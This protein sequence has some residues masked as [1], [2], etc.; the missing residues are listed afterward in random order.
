MIVRYFFGFLLVIVLVVIT[1]I[2]VIRGFRGNGQAVTSINLA[3]LSTTNSV[4]QFTDDGPITSQQSHQGLRIIVGQ[5]AATI[6][7]YQGYQNNIIQSQTFANNQDAYAVFLKALELENYTKGNNSPALA[8]AR[9]YCP[10]GDRYSFQIINGNS[11]SVQNFWSTSCGGQGTFG[12]NV[13]GVIALYQAQ[14][15]NYANIANA[16]SL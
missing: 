9:G 7:I 1:F 15:P 2:L 4:V 12:G 6:Q 5:Y 8:D 11:Q 16:V 13:S 10:Q 14:I 3:K